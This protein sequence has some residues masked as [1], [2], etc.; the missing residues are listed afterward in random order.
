MFIASLFLFLGGIALFGTSIIIEGNACVPSN[1]DLIIP[2]ISFLILLTG[3]VLLGYDAL[4]FIG[5]I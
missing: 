4:T 2:A 3:L 1:K 5:V